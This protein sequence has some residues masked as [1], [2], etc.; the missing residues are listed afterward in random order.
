MLPEGNGTEVE[1][2]VPIFVHFMHPVNRGATT[3]RHNFEWAE[4]ELISSFQD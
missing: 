2:V 4:Y 3:S 1:T